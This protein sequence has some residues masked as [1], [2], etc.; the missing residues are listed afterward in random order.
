MDWTDYQFIQIIKKTNIRE[1][2]KK[3]LPK[4]KKLFYL[5]L[6]IHIVGDLSQPLHVSAQGT[7]GG[8]S[9]K[10]TWFSAQSN[11]HRVWDENLIEYQQLSYTEYVK[12]I[13][14]PTPSQLKTW[15]GQPINQW[16]FES[17]TISQKLV[18]GMEQNAR[19]GYEYNFAQVATLNEQ[20]L[21]GGIRLASVLNNIFK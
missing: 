9:I 17:Y 11:L 7:S 6:V 12:A 14:F 13:N 18:D 10:V 3:N 21:K 2:K 4:D 16:I 20:L 1:L 19:L 8:N 15:L 5:K